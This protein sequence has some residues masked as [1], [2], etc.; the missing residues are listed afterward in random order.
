[1]QLKSPASLSDAF[2]RGARRPRSAPRISDE[3]WE[4]LRPTILQRFKTDSLA[5]IITFMAEEHNFRAS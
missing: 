5:N 4:R 2:A 3:A 1:M